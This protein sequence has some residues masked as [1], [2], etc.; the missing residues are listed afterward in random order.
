[1]VVAIWFS[2]P[3]GAL[4]AP[5]VGVSFSALD[6]IPPWTQW[7]L[8]T[9]GTY[10]LHCEIMFCSFPQLKVNFGHL[11]CLG[12]N[13]NPIRETCSEPGRGLQELDFVA[14][15]FHTKQ[16]NMFLSCYPSCTLTHHA[17]KKWRRTSQ[18]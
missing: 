10:N 14:D 9:C 2:V 17:L 16:V 11:S 1:M 5:Q 4:R 3:C 12:R 13:C 6:S 8:C 15:R 18:P 7:T